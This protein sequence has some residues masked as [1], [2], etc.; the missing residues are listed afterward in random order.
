MRALQLIVSPLALVSL[1][2]AFLPGEPTS[3]SALSFSA[4]ISLM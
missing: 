2:G 4:D 1:F 3:A